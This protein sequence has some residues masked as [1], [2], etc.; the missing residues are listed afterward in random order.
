MRCPQQ[1][2]RP[3]GRRTRIQ[4]RSAAQLS[5]GWWDMIAA[6]DGASTAELAAELGLAGPRAADKLVRAALARLRRHFG[7]ARDG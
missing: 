4:R 5:N 7:D 6:M 2:R 1:R 3:L